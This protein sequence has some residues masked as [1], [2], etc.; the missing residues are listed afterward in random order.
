MNIADGEISNVCVLHLWKFLT[1]FDVILY[2]DVHWKVLAIL[3]RVIIS[4]LEL[5]V[6][7]I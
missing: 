4:A 3:I 1:D 7:V 2:C 6:C 5:K